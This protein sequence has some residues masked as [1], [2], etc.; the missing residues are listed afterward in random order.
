MD[1]GGVPLAGTNEPARFTRRA[2]LKGALAAQAAVWAAPVITVL[3]PDPALAGSPPPT[4]PDDTGVEPGG[5][6]RPT[7]GISRV[8][9]QPTSRSAARSGAE[10]AA[11]G[12]GE[13]TEVLAFT[14]GPSTL[15]TGLGVG[16]IGTGAAAVTLERRRR[17]A[18][19]AQAAR[20]VGTRPE[21]AEGQVLDGDGHSAHRDD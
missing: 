21:D 15:L 12:T 19:R 18:Q 9:G 1:D 14:G 6:E 2:V 13:R 4:P 11:G 3:T 5:E 7:D 10:V 17:A 8:P 20:D 16:A